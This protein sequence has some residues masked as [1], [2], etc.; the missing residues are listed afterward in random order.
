[1]GQYQQ[2]LHYQEIDRRLRA[3]VEALETELARLES[4]LDSVFLE[5]LMQQ[6]NSLTANPIIAALLAHQV[7]S[8]NGHIPS[9]NDPSSFSQTFEQASA[10]SHETLSPELLD[11]GRLLDFGPQQIEEQSARFREFPAFLSASH[12]EI[13]LLPEDMFAF[14]DQQ[15]QTDPQVELPWWLR[16]ITITSGD[17][18]SG[19]PIDQESI[20]T[21]RL[22][23]RW[24][25]RWGRQPST[26]FTTEGESEETP[27][28]P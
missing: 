22:V 24:V 14:M 3:T 23:Q 21:N 6:A 10:A 27:D 19:R 16:K 15:A 28:A 17:A 12:P 2:W 5:Q 26:A 20:R 11:W 1:M 18:E 9:T 13:E 4:Q 25:E 8:T 7:A